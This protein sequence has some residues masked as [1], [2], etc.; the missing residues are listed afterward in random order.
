MGIQADLRI[1][2]FAHAYVAMSYI[3]MF[4]DSPSVQSCK[5][6]IQIIWFY[7]SA[8]PKSVPVAA[9][10]T[11]MAAIDSLTFASTD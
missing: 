9:Q 10:Q 1:S 11:K 7:F 5:K 4:S 8:V 3:K 2:T 6:Y